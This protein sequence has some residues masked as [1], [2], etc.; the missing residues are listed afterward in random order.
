MIDKRLVALLREYKRKEC[1]KSPFIMGIN[2]I[3]QL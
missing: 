1:C 3:I 2:L